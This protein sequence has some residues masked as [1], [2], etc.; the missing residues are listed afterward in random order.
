MR[1]FAGL[2]LNFMEA[3]ELDYLQARLRVIAQYLAEDT[4][5]LTFTHAQRVVS[6]L[7]RS[8]CFS[9]IAP[10]TMDSLAAALVQ[11]VAKARSLRTNTN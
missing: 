11:A 4:E 9:F 6:D 2:N 10:E 8:E 3:S 1:F 5:E 7:V